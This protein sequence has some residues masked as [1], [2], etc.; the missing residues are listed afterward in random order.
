MAD[1]LYQSRPKGHRAKLA[2][3]L[4]QS[5][6]LVRVEDAMETLGMDRV[7]ASKTLARWHAQGWLQRVGHGLYAAIPLDARATEQ[8]LED[9]WV[10]VPSLF[11]EAYI[12]GWTAA[13]H[14]DLTEQLFRDTL[15]FTTKKIRTRRHEANGITFVLRHIQS[16]A[17]FGTRTIWRGQERVQISD[18]HRTMIDMLADPSTG[19]GIRHV[20]DCFDAYLKHKDFNPGTLLSYAEKLGNGAVFKRMGFLASAQRGQEGLVLACRDRMTQG[21]AKLDP[22]IETPRLVKAWRLWIPETWSRDR[23][24]GKD[25]P[26]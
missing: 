4:G 16:K 17:L 22:A 9:P 7:A 8:V 20:A 5:G 2:S 23:R 25:R 3:L 13:E 15:V 6:Q 24:G 1:T 21:N 18:V 10:L 11:G 19:G 14:W 12:G 26:A